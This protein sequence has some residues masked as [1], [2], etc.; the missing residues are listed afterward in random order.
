MHERYPFY[1]PK[2]NYLATPCSPPD[3]CLCHLSTSDCP[4]LYLNERNSYD[5]S[6]EEKCYYATIQPQRSFNSIHRNMNCLP[7][8]DEVASDDNISYN[9]TLY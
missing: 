6:D 5:I 7:V 8:I 1:K 3:S 2:T 4:P 9:S